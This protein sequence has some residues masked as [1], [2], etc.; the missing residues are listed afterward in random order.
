MALY[1]S[2]ESVPAVVV[3]APYII[4][5]VVVR[6]HGG[7]DGS[8]QEGLLDRV[9]IASHIVVSRDPGVHEA[10]VIRA[11]K[12]VIRLVRHACFMNAAGIIEN[13]VRGPGPTAPAIGSLRVTNE[14]L[15]FGEII[16]PV[17]I[18]EGVGFELA[19]CGEGPA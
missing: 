14:D 6:F 7:P 16:G 3:A 17:V 19:D 18:D 12:S 4:V 10:C 13:L 2:D 8:F 11:G 5:E 9:Y 15:L 1:E